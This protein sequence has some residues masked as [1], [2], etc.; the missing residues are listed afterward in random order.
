MNHGGT[1]AQT[2]VQTLAAYLDDEITAMPNL[3][4]TAATTVG[5]LA[6]GS[7]D[8]GFGTINNAAAITGTVL[9][10]TTNFTMGDTVVTNGV[11]TDATGL[12]LAADVTITGDLIVSGDTITVNTATLAVEDPLIALAT[13]NSATDVLDIGIYGLYDT[14]GSLD[15]YAGLFRDADDA[16]KWKLFKDSQAVPTTTVNTSGTGYAVGTLVATLEGNV[17]GALTGNADTVTTNA[18]LTGM[19]TSS[20]N[21]A[22]LGAFTKAELTEAIS[23]GT[24]LY[25]GDLA[26]GPS[27]GFVIAMAVA[28]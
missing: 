28:L 4:T 7:I 10:A 21:A 18:N 26:V 25:D 12:S 17:T 16:G 23:D 5:V 2:T 1:M 13:G 11:I 8:T 15:L 3:V 19:V 22:S 27:A 20:G 14:S 24:P 9:T 6:N